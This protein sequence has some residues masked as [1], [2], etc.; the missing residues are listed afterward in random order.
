MIIWGGL[1]P[2]SSFE[3]R[4]CSGVATGRAW[5]ARQEERARIGVPR[6]GPV[7]TSFLGCFVATETAHS[8]SQQRL[9]CRNREL[10]VR[11]FGSQHSFGV[12]RR[13]AELMGWFCV[14]TVGRGQ[15]RQNFTMFFVAIETSLS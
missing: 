4:H 11:A 13:G 12:A 7:A 15:A 14:V 5:C 9:W 8:V 2:I 1:L 3:S 10:A 6:K